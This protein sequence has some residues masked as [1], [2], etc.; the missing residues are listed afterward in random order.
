MSG[1]PLAAYQCRLHL[2]SLSS[3][4]APS[5]ETWP[6]LLERYGFLKLLLPQNLYRRLFSIVIGMRFGL[7]LGSILQAGINNGLKLWLLSGGQ[8]LP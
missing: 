5:N 4:T 1:Q 6:K 2:D 3:V 8:Q 7:Q